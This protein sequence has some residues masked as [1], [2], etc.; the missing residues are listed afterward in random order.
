LPGCP[1]RASQLVKTA[2]LATYIA[3]REKYGA[4]PEEILRTEVDASRIRST[5]PGYCYK[6]AGYTFLRTVGTKVYLQAPSPD[7][8]ERLLAPS[9]SP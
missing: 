2:T 7:V 5:N 8:A 3:W 9:A 4:L 6:L 1:I